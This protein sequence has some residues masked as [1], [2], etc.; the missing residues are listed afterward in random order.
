MKSFKVQILFVFIMILAIVCVCIFANKSSKEEIKNMDYLRLHIRAN[1]N[2]VEDQNV[3]YEVKNKV[4]DILTPLVINAKSKNDLENILVLNER[5]IESQVDIFLKGK[6]FYYGCD[7]EINNEFFPTRTYE[8][9]TLNADY[10]DALIIKLG[11]G[12][13]NNWWCVVY[14]PLCFVGDDVSSQNVVYKSKL[15]EIINKFFN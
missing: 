3:K 12:T 15:K 9:V 1:S 6:G 2:S 8:D 13:G 7:M 11:S 5:H 10:Y 4:V 14:P